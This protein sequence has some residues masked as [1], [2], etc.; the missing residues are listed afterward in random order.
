MKRILIPRPHIETYDEFMAKATLQEDAATLDLDAPSAVFQDN[1]ISQVDMEINDDDAVDDEDL[2]DVELN[3]DDQLVQDLLRAMNSS[4]MM[5]QLDE[6]LFT[7]AWSSLG[8]AKSD[9][10]GIIR[11]PFL[12]T[13]PKHY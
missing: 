3:S 13:P 12:L 5:E 6:G 4:L 8:L 11:T 1:F 9:Y 10:S 2:N 7:R